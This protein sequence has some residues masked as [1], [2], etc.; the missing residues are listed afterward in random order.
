MIHHFDSWSFPPST[1]RASLLAVVAMAVT[2]SA[3]AQLVTFTTRTGQ[4]TVYC[5]PPGSGPLTQNSFSALAATNDTISVS[6]PGGFSWPS[7]SA[8]SHLDVV[9]TVAGISIV[10]NGSSTRGSNPSSGAYAVADAR[11][12]W[13]FTVSAPSHFTLQV[14]LNATSTDPAVPIQGYNLLALGGGA[15]VIPDPGTPPGAFTGALLSPGSLS[16]VGT[17]TLT[18]GQYYVSLSGRTEGNS[19]PFNGSFS[20]SLALDIG[21]GNTTS[22]CTSGTT[23]HGCTAQIQGT[24][25]PS[26]SATSG[27]TLAVTGM[28]GASQGLI[29]YG[30]SGRSA[31]PWGT[32]S[33]FVCVKSPTQRTSAQS[34]GG[35]SGACDGAM[36]L[37]WN[38]YVASHPS[39]IGAP[40]AAGQL[41]QAQGWFRDPPSPKSTMLSDAL[42]FPVCP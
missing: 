2:R 6:D 25:T 17:G 5:G 31:A 21:C 32:S 20:H 16:V 26:A 8:T 28:E 34:G 11:D 22:Y 36:S 42:E 15:Q 35:T 14:S 4:N 9:P 41:V 30:V 7:S 39:A 33:S 27:F 23:T 38:S 3:P 29:F 37:D 1:R 40:F 24:G 10:E 19:S 18:A 12:S 13:E